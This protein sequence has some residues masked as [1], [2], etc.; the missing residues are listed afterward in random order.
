MSA[1]NNDSHGVC[2][3]AASTICITWKSIRIPCI[4][5]YTTFTRM[6]CII[7]IRCSRRLSWS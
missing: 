1:K 5:S 6:V 4:T 3:T 7:S 2:S